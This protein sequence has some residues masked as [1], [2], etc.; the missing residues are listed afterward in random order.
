V[1]ALPDGRTLHA[2][3]SGDPAGQLVIHHHGTPG[4][5]LLR[6][7]WAKDAQERGIRLVGYDRAGYGGS[8]RHAGRSV[9]DVTADIA[10]LADSLGVHRFFTW[11]VSGGGPHALACAA[12]LGD[13]LIAAAVLASAAPYDASG[14]DFL[15]GMGQDNIDEFGAA[16]EGEE[17]LRA[18]LTPQSDGLLEST[19]ENLRDAMES[20]LPAVDKAALTGETA[21]FFHSSMTSGLR[22]SF[23]GWLDDDVAF[24]TPWSFEVSSITVPTLV[25]QGEQDLM[26]PFAHGQW[27]AAALPGATVR[28][29]PDEGHISLTEKVPDVHEWLLA[30]G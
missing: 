15:A 9:S 6:R 7:E 26:V 2:Y 25:M 27:I 28:L 17:A 3:E 5:G 10:A 24:V 12:L 23:D 22:S 8:S 18:Y 21:E 14:L 11:G 30:Q 4:S 19:P 29:L 13:R 16:L 20:L 1:V